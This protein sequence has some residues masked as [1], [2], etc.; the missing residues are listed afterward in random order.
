MGVGRR[1]NNPESVRFGDYVRAVNVQRRQVSYSL[2]MPRL[3][4]GADGKPLPFVPPRLQVKSLDVYRLLKPYLSVRFLDQFKAVVPLAIYLAIFQMVVLR[5]S[6]KDGLIIGGGLM[7]VMV[8]LML[9]M[10]GLKLGLMPFGESIGSN[11]PKRLSL[12]GVLAIAFILGVGVTFAEPA[13]GA[14]QVA[15]SIIDP[16]KAPYLYTLLTDRSM[17]TVLVVGAGVGVAAVLGTMRFMYGWSLKPMI[18]WSL[19]PTLLLSIY[20]IT[21]P[22]LAAVV[23]LAWDCGGVT[24]GPVTVPLVL[25]LGIGVASAA[26]KGDSSLSGF[27]IVTL[28]SIFPILFVILLALYVSFT[29]SPE[30][31]IA[32]AASLQAASAGKIVPWY[33]STPYVE[34][35][36]GIRAIVPL[37]LFLMFVLR[38]L[39]RQKLANAGIIRYGIALAVAGMVI[40][41]IG[42]TYG[43]AKL[44][45][46]SGGLVPGAFTRI[47]A[48]PESPLYALSFG[49]FIAALFAWALGFGA[50]LAEPAL[51]ALGV[52]VENLTNGAFRK[53]LLM[54]AVALG[55]AVGIALGV[56]KIIFDFS[57]MYILLPGYIIAVVLT[58]MASEEYVNIGWD[59]AGVTTGPVTVP[60]VLAMGLGFGKAVGATEG[61]GILAAASVCPIV[62]VLALGVYVD[63][64]ARRASREKAAVYPDDGNNNLQAGVI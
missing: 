56:V 41:N 10:E 64:R 45:D 15:G 23:G 31:I 19:I 49:I 50:T 61:F 12:G 1:S 16:A 27:G 63:W 6:V 3:S 38:W 18:Y 2:L 13:I 14:L 28:A 11:L 59:S 32:N 33:E 47:A 9:F 30:T 44:G 29:V 24:T 5:E 17:A 26:G 60:L 25:A 7:A 48:M 21:N 51:N 58:A 37:V 8:G 57:I 53:S 40:F 54:Y 36:L 52:T 62:S 55:V 42:L 22:N 20:A 46:Q 34:T 35:I 43:L 39:L 4:R